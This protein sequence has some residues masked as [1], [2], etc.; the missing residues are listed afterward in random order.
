MSQMPPQLHF[1]HANGF[2]IGAYRQFLAPLRTVGSV[3]YTDFIG[4]HPDYPVSD[5]WFHLCNHLIRD[6]E[7][8]VRRHPGEVVEVRVPAI[9]RG[10][11]GFPQ[12]GSAAWRPP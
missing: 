9:R 12:L 2:P 11:R 3:S 7:A 10:K 5:N 4:H 6:V 1:S 8:V